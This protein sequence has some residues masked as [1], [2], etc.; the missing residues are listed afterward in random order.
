MANGFISPPV[1]VSS[2]CYLI[3][4]VPVIT[5]SRAVFPCFPMGQLVLGCS[6][7]VL[8]EKPGDFLL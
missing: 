7:L 2:P 3:V 1:C 5:Y 6:P 8:P 4:L